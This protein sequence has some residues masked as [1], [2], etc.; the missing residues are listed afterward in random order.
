M[1]Y[2]LGSVKA[3]PPALNLLLMP[4]PYQ[5][6]SESFLVVKNKPDT[7]FKQAWKREEPFCRWQRYRF[8]EKWSTGF[9]QLQPDSQ[10]TWILLPVLLVSIPSNE[11]VEATHKVRLRVALTAEAGRCRN[12]LALQGYLTS[13]VVSLDTFNQLF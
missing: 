11:A 7:G 5:N 1:S 4:G 9:N 13:G 6:P 12:S 8:S 2:F 10:Y 3:A